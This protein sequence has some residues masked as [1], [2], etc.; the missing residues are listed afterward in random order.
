C[1]STLLPRRVSSR[2]KE[3]IVW[4]ILHSVECRYKFS[5]RVNWKKLRAKLHHSQETCLNAWKEYSEHEGISEFPLVQPLPEDVFK[6]GPPAV[7][8]P[9]FGVF[10]I[11]PD[12]SLESASSDAVSEV[13][14]MR[15]D[16]H[17]C[18]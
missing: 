9:P 14:N 11:G 6:A 10:S 5:R 7:T 2:E 13:A 4:W 12:D 15:S 17:I 18:G 8:L 3:N 1:P 16:A